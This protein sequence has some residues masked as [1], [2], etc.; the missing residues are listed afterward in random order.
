MKRLILTIS[1]AGALMGAAAQTYT[2]VITDTLC[3]AQHNMKGH[4]DAKDQC[5][6]SSV[7]RTSNGQLGEDRDGTF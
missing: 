2:G 4:F 5:D 3:G 1:L 6:K 7:D